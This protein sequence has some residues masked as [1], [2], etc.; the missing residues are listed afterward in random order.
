MLYRVLLLSLILTSCQTVSSP[1]APVSSESS[2]HAALQSELERSQ[3][4][5]LL[6]A[7]NHLL[8]AEMLYLQNAGTL[9]L[10]PVDLVAF[11]AVEERVLP[12]LLASANAL[13][14]AVD[15]EDKERLLSDYL[16]LVELLY[17]DALGGMNQNISLYQG[18]FEVSLPFSQQDLEALQELGRIF[19]ASSRI[20]NVSAQIGS[21]A[22]LNEKTQAVFETLKQ[23]QSVVLNGVITLSSRIEDSAALKSAYQVT[24]ST[25]SSPELLRLLSQLAERVFGAENVAFNQ[26]QLNPDQNNPNL[27][28]LVIRES[29]DTYRLLQIDK[30][31]LL[32]QVTQDSRGLKAS[33][34]LT[35]ASFVIVKPSDNSN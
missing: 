35:D 25:L 28:A 23:Q 12:S 17:S 34:V 21:Y 2:T 27:L 15:S 10:A 19:E 16:N 18:L 14:T 13:N 30:G 8:Q 3:D 5:S 6:S 7:R 4:Q 32:N 20:L 1:S 31:V 24:A 33:E 29:S 26:Q 9:R 11:K 22:F